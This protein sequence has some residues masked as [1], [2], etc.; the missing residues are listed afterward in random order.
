MF[1]RNKETLDAA[2]ETLTEKPD[3]DE[4][5]GLKLQI[6]AVIQRAI[7]SL[8]GYYNDMMQDQ[9]VQKLE[10]FQQAYSFRAPEISAKA[11]YKTV[12]NSLDKTRCPENLP[13]HN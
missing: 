8:W 2:I 10:R 5:H 6:N 3:G 11:R 4:K 7:K 12:N 13:N 1:T 9:K